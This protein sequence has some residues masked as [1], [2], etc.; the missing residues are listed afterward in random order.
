MFEV[1]GAVLPE[2]ID[3]NGHMHDAR[4]I[5]AFHSA[6]WDFFKSIE[7]GTAYRQSGFGMFNLGMNLDYFSEMMLDD[8]LRIEV[9]V[10]DV[11]EKLLHLYLNLYHRGTGVLSASNERLLIHVDLGTRKSTPFPSWAYQRL[12]DCRNE[13]AALPWPEMQGRKLG[14]RR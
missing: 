2:W 7:L 4:Y 1:E 10:L 6:A 13:S 14:I 11:N 12:L 5:D 8:P 3:G 9:R